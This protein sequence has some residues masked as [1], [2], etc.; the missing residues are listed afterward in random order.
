M[1]KSLLHRRGHSEYSDGPDFLCVG[2]H[3]GGTQWLFDQLDWHPD[4]WMPPMKELHYFDGGKRAWQ[5]AKQMYLAASEDLDAAN[6]ARSKQLRRPLNKD[7]LKFLEDFLRLTPAQIDFEAYAELFSASKSLLSG[8]ITPGYSTLHSGTV[9]QIMNRF[10]ALKIVFIA[11]DPV[12]RLWSALS[13]RARLGRGPSPDNQAI[14]A[15]ELE[16]RHNYRRTFQ[17]KIVARWRRYAPG[18]QVGLF[19]FD[20]LTANSAEFRRRVLTFLGGDPDDAS[21]VIPAGY[22][23]KERQSRKTPLPDDLRAV[24]AQILAEEL[25]VSAR[26]FGGPAESWPAKY[27]L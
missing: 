7:D 18:S 10:P 14:I 15:S 19:F 6:A 20:D 27:G 2:A 5:K 21:G 3:K 25:K 16:K 8:D 12:E 9:E 23:R 17:T 1:I 4:F 11:R 13:M 24:I 22:N 26:E